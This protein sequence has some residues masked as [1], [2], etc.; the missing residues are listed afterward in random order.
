MRSRIHYPDVVIPDNAFSQLPLLLNLFSWLAG[1]RKWAWSKG[2]QSDVL[3]SDIWCEGWLCQNT[4]GVLNSSAARPSS[5]D[6]EKLLHLLPFSMGHKEAV[7]CWL[8]NARGIKVNST[9]A[10]VGGEG[11]HPGKLRVWL[12]LCHRW[13]RHACMAAQ[14]H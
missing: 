7:R 8:M 9:K 3:V 4:Q 6:S 5:T 1:E 13:S 14:V 10:R 11:L 12:D 2:K